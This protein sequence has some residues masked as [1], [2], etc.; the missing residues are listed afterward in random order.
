MSSARTQLSKIGRKLFPFRLVIGVV[1]AL[2]TLKWLSLAPFFGTDYRILHSIA[3]AVI[4][5]GLSLRAWGAGSAGFHTRSE[6]IEAP[7]LATGGAFAYLRNP[8]YAGSICIGIGM[9]MLVG[10]PKAFLF[11]AIA[12]AILYFSIVPA[13]EDFLLR[14]FGKEYLLYRQAVPRMIPRLRP[15]PGRKTAPFHWAAVLG[16]GWIL[17]VLLGIYGAMALEEYW[18]HIGLF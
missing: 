2:G 12:F 8:I 13:E 1:V 15:W 17:L 7:Q 10:D 14:Q 18:D 9:S 6:R 16:E 4:G 5:A 11:A 3:L